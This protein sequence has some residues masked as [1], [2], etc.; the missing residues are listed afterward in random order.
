M[1]TVVNTPASGTSDSGSGMGMVVGIIVVL[2]IVVLLA[3][4]ALPALRGGGT[5]APAAN[6]PAGDGASDVNLPEQV[7][8]NV[9][10]GQ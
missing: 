8:V 5:S 1:T 4:F 2:V 9:N 10:P 6:A 3:M 7:D